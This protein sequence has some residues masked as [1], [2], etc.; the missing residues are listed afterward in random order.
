MWET[1]HALT[2]LRPKLRGNIRLQAFL[3]GSNSS[4]L[5]DVVEPV[6]SVYQKCSLH[7]NELYTKSVFQNVNINYYSTGAMNDVK[8]GFDIYY[9]LKK[10]TIYMYIN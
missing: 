5:G 7:N 3:F 9:S 2:A 1:T 8:V 6:E 10:V 4:A